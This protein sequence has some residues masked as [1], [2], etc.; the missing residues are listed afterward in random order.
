MFTYELILGQHLRKSFMNAW[1]TVRPRWRGFGWAQLMLIFIVNSYFSVVIAYTL[2][3]IKASCITP[4]PWTVGGTQKYW[5]EVVLG[6]L[7][8]PNLIKGLGGFKGEMLV[9]LTVF[10]VIIFFSVAF[11]KEVLAKI[12]YVTGKN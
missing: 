3:Y 4:L 7:P 9:G 12:T 10:W 2:P 1:N 5:E 11:G 6:E 8:N